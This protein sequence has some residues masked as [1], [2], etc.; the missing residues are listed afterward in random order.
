M[1]VSQFRPI[2]VRISRP[3]ATAI[4]KLCEGPP[5]PIDLRAQWRKRFADWQAEQDRRRQRVD[6]YLNQRCARVGTTSA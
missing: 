1:T 5:D 2:P 4:T 3:L 6:W